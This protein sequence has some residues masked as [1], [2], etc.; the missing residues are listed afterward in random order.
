[1]DA[2][3]I[4]DMWS[5]GRDL[6]KLVSFAATPKSLLDALPQKPRGVW[7]DLR[8]D[9]RAPKRSGL[10]VLPELGVDLTAQATEATLETGSPRAMYREQLRL[11]LCGARKQPALV[12]G[13]PGCGK[14]TLV[15]QT[16]ADLLS[17]DD[18]DTHKNI[19]RV[20][21]VWRI[22]G[23]RIIAGMSFL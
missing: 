13:A 20:H 17:A 10:K 1:V 18:Y 15:H 9:R 11:L 6:I 8:D 7:D 19:D 5:N 14:T 16:I 2:D 12:V 23:K 3:A 22:A 21:H 4:D